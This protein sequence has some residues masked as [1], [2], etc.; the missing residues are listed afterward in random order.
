LATSTSTD[1]GAIASMATEASA[2]NQVGAGPSDID[3]IIAN[4]NGK[5]V[6]IV[7]GPKTKGKFREAQAEHSAHWTSSAIDF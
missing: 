2:P 1:F 5:D 4:L 6:E 7:A 3:A